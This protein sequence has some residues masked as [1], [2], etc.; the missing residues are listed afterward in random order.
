MEFATQAILE[1]MKT[2]DEENDDEVLQ[3]NF[4]GVKIIHKECKVT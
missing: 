4:N 1:L 2:S 3:H